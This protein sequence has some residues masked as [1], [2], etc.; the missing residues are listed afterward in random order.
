MKKKDNDKD[1]E[2]KITKDFEEGKFKELKNKKSVFQK[3]AS[4]TKDR[5]NLRLDPKTKEKFLKK[6]EAEG[7][8]YQT[9]INSVLKKYIDGKLID[10]SYEE[11]ISQIK[12]EIKSLK[13]IA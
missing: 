6:S 11:L 7:I 1:L 5:I 2:R 13:K 4:E 9:L 12:K 3:L 8:P 10:S